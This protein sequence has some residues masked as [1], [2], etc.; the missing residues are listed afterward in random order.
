MILNEMAASISTPGFNLILLISIRNISTVSDK[1]VLRYKYLHFKYLLS[2][3]TSQL[4][5]KNVSGIGNK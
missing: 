1:Y 3:R 4:E 2:G 5:Y